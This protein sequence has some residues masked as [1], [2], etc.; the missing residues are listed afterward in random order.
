MTKF[1]GVLFDLD[2]T[3]IDSEHYYYSNWQP[4]LLDSFGLDIS[5]E[6]WLTYFAGHTLQRNVDFLREKWGIETNHKFMWDQTRASY[7]QMDMTEI[8]L[9]PYAHELLAYLK[10]VGLPIGLVTSSYASTV[11]T[12]LGHHELL[13]YFDFFVTRDDVEKPKPNAEPYLQ[14]IERI[15]LPKASVLAVEDTITGATA[16][17]SAGLYCLGVSAHAVEQSR[18][19]T[20]A[21]DLF[22]DL[23][24][25]IE[26]GR[27]KWF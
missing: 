17:K 27:D 1:K 20:K 10:A 7:Q 24:D 25:V 23:G 15:A 13:P 8:R 5:F 21:D 12:V 11:Q 26:A 14:G 9:M 3:L 19:K 6:D 16:A 4:I 18:L 2:G 22:S